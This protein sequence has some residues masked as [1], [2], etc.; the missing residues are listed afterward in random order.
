MVGIRSS[1]GGVVNEVEDFMALHWKVL[2]YS[3]WPRS[4]AVRA[5]NKP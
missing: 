3:N 4:L 1:L 2:L 5:C